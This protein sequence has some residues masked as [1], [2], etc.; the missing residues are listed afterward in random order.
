[1]GRSCY[2]H[3]RLLYFLGQQLAQISL[4]LFWWLAAKGMIILD[5][6]KVR[7]RI[8]IAMVYFRLVEMRSKWWW[9][10]WWWWCLQWWRKGEGQS[11][12]RNGDSLNV[13]GALLHLFQVT[14]TGLPLQT[15]PGVMMTIFGVVVAVLMSPW[16][17][18]IIWRIR[19]LEL[20]RSIRISTYPSLKLFVTIAKHINCQKYKLYFRPSTT[21][22]LSHLT[23]LRLF[24]GL[25]ALL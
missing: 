10:W 25:F 13:S 3:T 24:F 14:M 15:L 8:K 16:H 20:Q 4:R 6:E 5:V 18:L 9:W 23:C 17:Y 19:F 11:K 1:M 22:T 21:C 12:E 7:V 2:F